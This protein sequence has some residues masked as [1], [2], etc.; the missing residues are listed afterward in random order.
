MN[1]PLCCVSCNFKLPEGRKFKLCPDCGFPVRTLKTRYQFRA[2]LKRGRVGQLY[3]VW[4]SEASEDKV[5]KVMRSDLFKDATQAARFWRE[6]RVTRQLSQRSPHIVRLLDHGEDEHF[7]RYYV[8]EYLEGQTLRDRLHASEPH[9]LVEIFTIVRQICEALEVAHNHGFLH[10]D[11]SPS[12]IFLDQQG[13]SSPWV[14]LLDFGMAKALEGT[15]HKG[16]TQG[17]VGTPAYTPPEQWQAHRVDERSDLYALGAVL[18]ELL[19]LSPPFVTEGSSLRDLMTLM[20]LHSTT[21]PESLA[22]RRPDLHY[23]LELNN[24][25]QKLL[26]KEPTNRYASAQELWTALAPYARMKGEV[27]PPPNPVFAE[28]RTLW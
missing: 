25:V 14:K 6:I 2:S 11:L 12:N 5:V 22:E 8:M 1:Q 27:S 28:D 19:T 23:P 17:M 26:A 13:P 4:D 3:R 9:S 15:A 16:L 21:T 24:I 18:Y 7:G 20:H 10:R